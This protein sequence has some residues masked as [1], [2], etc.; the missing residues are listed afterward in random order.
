MIFSC[1]ENVLKG[2]FLTIGS[3]SFAAR[4]SPCSIAFKI[5]VTSL[6]VL[7]VL[8]RQNVF[9]LLYR[10]LRNDSNITLHLP[11]TTLLKHPKMATFS[12]VTKHQN[13]SK[14]KLFLVLKNTT[15]DMVTSWHRFVTT[16]P[17]FSKS[18]PNTYEFLGQR[19]I[20]KKLSVAHSIQCPFR[21]YSK[22]QSQANFL[23]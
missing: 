1:R 3:R 8:E 15:I 9:T 12:W 22:K 16:N 5:R 23:Q 13:S 7:L 14:S 17:N 11:F 2:D 18:S 21:S 10:E 19:G 20:L 6:M 4:A